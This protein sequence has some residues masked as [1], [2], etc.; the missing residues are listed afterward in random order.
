MM[1]APLLIGDM[2]SGRMDTKSKTFR[3]SCL[4]A[5]LWGLVVPAIGRNPVTV[6]IA[7]QIANVF[8]LPLTV[9]AIMLLLNRKD[10][11]GV[12]RAGKT[13]NALLSSA[14]VFS[15]VIACVGAKALMEFKG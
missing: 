7:A 2:R 8:V 14:L 4:A 1:V 6:T 12:H 10:V 15:A 5:A 11:M 3:F 9:L 13:M